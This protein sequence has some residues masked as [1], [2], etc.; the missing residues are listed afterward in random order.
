MI[1]FQKDEKVSL[2][3]LW[4]LVTTKVKTFCGGQRVFQQDSGNFKAS[5]KNGE[6]TERCIFLENVITSFVKEN[7]RPL[8]NW[9]YCESDVLILRILTAN[10]NRLAAKCVPF[11]V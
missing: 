9:I 5:T 2:N 1:S 8:K 3:Y 11:A 10:F 4:E 7:W 6:S